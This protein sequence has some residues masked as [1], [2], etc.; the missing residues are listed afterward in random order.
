MTINNCDSRSALHRQEI[1]SLQRLILCVT[2]HVMYSIVFT[3]ADVA[4][5]ILTFPK[6]NYLKY[7][8]MAKL[9]NQ[10]IGKCF[11]VSNYLITTIPKE[12]ASL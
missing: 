6:A 7:Q 8:V 1:Y 11:Q 12:M 9:L 2:M 3:A 10:V 4:S 5:K